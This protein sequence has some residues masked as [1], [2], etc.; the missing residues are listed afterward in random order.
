MHN[1]NCKL[2]A[3][4]DDSILSLKQLCVNFESRCG[5]VNEEFENSLT[6]LKN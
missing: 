4:I 5:K 3:K 2:D 6:K 1:K